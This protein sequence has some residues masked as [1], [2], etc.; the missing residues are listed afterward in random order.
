MAA[1]L[2]KMISAKNW[3]QTGAKGGAEWGSLKVGVGVVIFSTNGRLCN[4]A[5]FSF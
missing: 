4:N 5:Q 2:L 1:P 3:H